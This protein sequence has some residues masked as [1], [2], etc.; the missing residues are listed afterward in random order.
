[1]TRQFTTAAVAIAVLAGASPALAQDG[2]PYV[3][4]H[5]GT[6][7][8]DGGAALSA[9][10]S[11]GYMTA[12]RVAFELELSVSPGL[13]FGDLGFGAEAPPFPDFFPFP[14]LEATGRLLT[15][16]S[17]VV[18]EV[19]ATERLRVA[20]VGG[21]GMANLHRDILLRYPDI[22]FPPGFVPPPD[23]ELPPGFVLPPF[24]PSFEIVER[25]IAT[26]ENALSLN[27][28]GIVEYAVSP[29]FLLGVD[30]R[31]THAFVDPDGMNNARVTARVRWR[32]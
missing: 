12:R 13:D 16:H 17:N 28:G 26:S 3:A 14:T 30:A 7:A 4:G 24:I 1:M 27:A 25:R 18:A 11:I 31:Y 29:R 22:V 5:T 20:V 19:G 32:F 8:G 21:G 15:F 10:G 23:L 2:G 6:L 9:G